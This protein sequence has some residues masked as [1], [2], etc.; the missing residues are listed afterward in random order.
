[1]FPAAFSFV[2]EITAKV[3]TRSRWQWQRRRLAVGVMIVE[4]VS[5]SEQGR[6]TLCCRVA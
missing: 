3:V 5:E 4:V 1:M 6:E 2:F